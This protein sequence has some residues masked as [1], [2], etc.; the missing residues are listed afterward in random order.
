M[1]ENINYA[2]FYEIFDLPHTTNSW[3]KVTELHVWLLMVRVMAEAKGTHLRNQISRAMWEELRIQAKW[4]PTEYKDAVP[5][6][7]WF[8]NNMRKLHDDFIDTTV[9]Y[10]KALLWGDDKIL[11]DAIWQQFFYS[12]CND[13]LKIELLVK[14]VRKMVS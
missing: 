13:I 2:D 3:Y 6:P 1:I 9:E 10:D 4:A 5:D 12:D 7:H 14:Y 11:A 8:K